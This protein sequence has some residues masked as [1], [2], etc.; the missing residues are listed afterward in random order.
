MAGAGFGRS[1][2]AKGLDWRMLHMEQITQELVIE[3][4]ALAGCGGF[5]PMWIVVATSGREACV[6]ATLLTALVSTDR[7]NFFFA[8]EAGGFRVGETLSIRYRDEGSG[9][10][11]ITGVVGSVVAR[12]GWNEIH[13]VRVA[14]EGS[15]VEAILLAA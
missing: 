10:L 8:F 12:P 9:L 11:T 6:S 14:D 4:G 5:V 2:R 15:E 1:Q 7:V 13:V 3:E